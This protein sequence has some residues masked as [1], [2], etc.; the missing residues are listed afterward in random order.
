MRCHFPLILGLSPLSIDSRLGQTPRLGFWTV[1]SCFSTERQ[2]A[3]RN[4]H[5]EQTGF[6]LRRQAKMGSKAMGSQ[7]KLDGQRQ[8]NS[9]TVN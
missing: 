5:L 8:S 4:F 2:K 6:G 9:S 7:G 3:R 1:N